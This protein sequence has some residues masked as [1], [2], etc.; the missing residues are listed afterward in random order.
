MATPKQV[1]A[2]WRRRLAV[3]A[4]YRNLFVASMDG[5]VVLRDLAREAGLFSISFDGDP[6]GTVF[7]EGKRAMVLF[8]MRELRWSEQ[9]LMGLARERDSE[10]PFAE[11]EEA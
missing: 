3:N 5:P 4:A 9:D 6:Y 8:I 7:N 10:N 11:T 2:Q 1:I